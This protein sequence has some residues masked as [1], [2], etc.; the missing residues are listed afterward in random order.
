[1]SDRGFLIRGGSVYDP[2]DGTWSVRDI[3]VQGGVIVTDLTTDNVLPIDAAGCMVT[4]GW[5]D[6]HVHYYAHS[7]EPGISPDAV[8]FPSGI[9]T[10]VDAGSSGAA[11]YE[12]YRKGVMQYSDVRILNMLYMAS[13]GI[14]TKQHVSSGEIREDAIRR[15]FRQY[16]D[17]LT[18]LKLMMQKG[19]VAAE[20]AGEV[21]RRTVALAE[22]IGAEGI[23]CNVTVHITDPVM[24]LELLAGLLRPGDVICHIYQGKGDETCLD[25]DGR[26]REGLLAARER[27]VLFDACNGCNNMDIEVARA[28]IAQGFRPDIISSDMNTSGSFMQPLHSLPRIMSKYLMLGMTLEEIL[29]AVTRTPATLLHRASLASLAPGTAADLTIFRVIDKAV[30]YY[31]RGQHP[32]TLD[33]RNAVIGQ[34]VLVPQLTMKDGVI[35]F[36]QSDYA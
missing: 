29:T 7:N 34:Q 9:T 22:E 10:V 21:V 13:G 14:I 15:L 26:I 23:P 16:P 25:A 6:A 19:I 30:P 20:D 5:I 3:A 12:M 31:D 18:G 28:A 33:G 35:V 27:G 2:E 17:N 32:V 11:T 8:S 24:D 4:T 36:C 1:M